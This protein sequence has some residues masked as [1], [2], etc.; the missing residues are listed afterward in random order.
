MWQRSGEAHD[1]H[2]GSVCNGAGNP[3]QADPIRHFA[4]IRGPIDSELDPGQPR[5]F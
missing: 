5:P 2:V 3:I 4:N 1:P